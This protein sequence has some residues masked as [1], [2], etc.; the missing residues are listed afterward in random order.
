MSLVLEEAWTEATLDLP[1][2]VTKEWWA[3]MLE[4]YSEDGRSYHNIQHLEEKFKQFK[5]VKQILKNPNAVT[6]AIFFH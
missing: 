3:K 5:T 1:K 2:E 6:L 4:K